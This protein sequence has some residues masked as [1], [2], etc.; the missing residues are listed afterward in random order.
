MKRI[1]VFDSGLGGLTVVKAILSEMPK[2][3]I[4]FFADAANVPYGDKTP[5]EIMALSGQNASILNEYDLKAMVIACNTSDS[6]AGDLLKRSYEI[7]VLGVIQAAAKEALR[8]TENKKIA[9]LATKA[10]VLSG[11]YQKQIK[12]LNKEIAVTAIPCPDLVPLIEEG[13]FVGNDELL[14]RSIDSYLK[15]IKESGSDTVILGCTHYELLYDL[16]QKKMPEIRIVSSSRT[17]VQELKEIL[18]GSHQ[19]SRCKGKDIYLCSSCSK[20]LDEIAAKII[21]DIRLQKK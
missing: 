4:V 19:R 9:A 20:R 13:R 8:Q 3:N 21:P 14:D 2:E 15:E 17:V 5:E 12:K 16:I 18:N 10:T 11:S 7:P 6:V 1:G